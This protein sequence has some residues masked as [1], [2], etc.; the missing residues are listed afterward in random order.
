MGSYSYFSNED[1]EVK[2]WNGL[3]EFFSFWENYLKEN[4]KDEGLEDYMSRNEM[5]NEEHKIIT[6][7]SW[8]GIKLISYW[9]D[10]QL[11]FFELVS[12]YI[13]GR[14]E[15][16]FENKDEAGYIDFEEGECNISMGDMVWKTLNPKDLFNK[17]LSIKINKRIMLKKIKNG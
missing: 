1:I 3:V 5:L 14:V 7:E 10:I 17:K 2:D 15:W 13:E 9:Y 6:F 16:E 4:H 11:I 8:G 12:E